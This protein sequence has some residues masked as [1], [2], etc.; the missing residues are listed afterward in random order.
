MLNLTNLTSYNSY[1][2]MLIIIHNFA[3]FNQPK[4]ILLQIN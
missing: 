3:F 4:L 1:K 2:I